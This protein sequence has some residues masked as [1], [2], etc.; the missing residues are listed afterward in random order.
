VEEEEEEEEEAAEGGG[1]TGSRHFQNNV[2][3]V[4]V[5]SQKLMRRLVLLLGS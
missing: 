4:T 1:I 2:G 3:V 5:G